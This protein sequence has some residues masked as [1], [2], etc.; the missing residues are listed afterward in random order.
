MHF[1]KLYLTI[2]SSQGL[3]Q[4][5]GPQEVPREHV[6]RARVERGGGQHGPPHPDHADTHPRAASLLA[7]T[8]KTSNNISSDA[9]TATLMSMESCDELYLY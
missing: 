7:H 8:V 3:F 6:V 4:S 1:N 5:G 2:K 9:L